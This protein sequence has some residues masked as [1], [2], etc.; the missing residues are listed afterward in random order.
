MS[1]K[2]DLQQINHSITLE[3][4][5]EF[6]SRFREQL[7]AIVQ[8]NFASALPYAET[9]NKEVFNRLINI[10]GSVGIRIYLG[11]DEQN[12]V[13]MIVVAVDENNDR[14][15]GGRKQPGYFVC[16][17][18]VCTWFDWTWLPGERHF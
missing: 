7:R 16:A 3:K 4:A 17:W 1:F 12:Q 11:L 2:T 14:C 5:I 9:F 8:P 13:R 10:T 15:C 6:T 18:H